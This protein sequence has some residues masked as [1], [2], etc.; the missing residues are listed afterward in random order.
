MRIVRTLFVQYDARVGTRIADG[1]TGK[2]ASLC[3][4]LCMKFSRT[5]RKSLFI[6]AL[7]L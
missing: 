1:L 2:R 7:V 6:S 5:H 3:M 4:Y